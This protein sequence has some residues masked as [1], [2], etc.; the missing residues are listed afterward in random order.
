MFEDEGGGPGGKGSLFGEEGASDED[1]DDFFTIRKPD[2]EEADTDALDS[3]KLQLLSAALPAAS[4]S[5]SSSSS[6]YSSSLPGGKHSS[7]SVLAKWDDQDLCQ[8]IKQDLFVTG[9]WQDSTEGGDLLN[10][11]G[12]SEDEDEQPDHNDED[13]EDLDDDNEEEEEDHGITVLDDDGVRRIGETAKQARARRLEAKKALKA[14]FDDT[15]DEEEAKEAQDSTYLDELKQEMQSQSERNAAAFADMDPEQRFQ[16]EGARPGSYVRIQLENVPCELVKYFDL[17]YPVILGGLLAGEQNMGFL[18]ARLKKHRWHK[19]ILK[20][21]DPQIFSI[22]WRRFQSMP[23]FGMEERGESER[24]RFLKYTPEHMH[25]IAV[26]YGPL[27]APN[28]GIMSFSNTLDTHAG[29]RTT[30]TGTVLQTDCSTQIVKKLKLTGTPFKIFKNTAFVRDMFNSSLEVAKFEGAKLRTVSGIRGQIKK[31]LTGKGQ[32]PDGAFRATFEDR[33]LMSDIV[34]CR[35]WAAV[36]PKEYYNPVTSLLSGDKRW[37]GM[38]SVA[39]LRRDKA[40]AVPYNA[41]SEYKPIERQERKFNPLLIPA[42]LQR[43]LPFKSKP[44]LMKARASN[45]PLLETRRAVPLEK[46]EKQSYALMQ[47]IFTVRNERKKIRHE[48]NLK[49]REKHIRAQAAEDAKHVASN[50][51]LKRKRAAAAQQGRPLKY[52]RYSAPRK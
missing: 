4:S 44:K 1:D 19:K 45:K 27:A 30:S 7:H 3:V 50:K 35:T 17:T 25:C 11:F 48:A 28:T 22:G 38:R 23:I 43:D 12:S 8:Q 49:K 13:N 41:D 46:E 31:A 15:Y 37:V 10:R 5:S 39:Q 29:F 2:P 9:D 34:F 6:S 32:G 21:N 47:K 24:V 18:T 42:G 16:L 36:A 40:L 51:E 14:K 26:F 52:Q 20:T 33:V